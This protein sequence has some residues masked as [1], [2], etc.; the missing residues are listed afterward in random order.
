M[1]LAAEAP[2]T[3]TEMCLGSDDFAPANKAP[4]L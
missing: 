4:D 2:P 3:E 1:S